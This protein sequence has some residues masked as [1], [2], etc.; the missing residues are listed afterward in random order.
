MKQEDF[1]SGEPVITGSPLNFT[2]QS[3]LSDE[4]QAA[5]AA[6]F[7]MYDYDLGI[8]QYYQQPQIY[9]G[10]E[11]YNGNFMNPPTSYNQAVGLGANPYVGGISPYGNPQPSYNMY[12]MGNPVLQPGYMYSQPMYQPPV[13]QAPTTMHIPGLNFSGEYLPT[14]GYEDKIEDMKVKYWKKYQEA[15]VK[16]ITDSQ[17]SVYGSNYMNGFNYYGAP[18]YNPYQYNSVNGELMQEINQIRDEARENRQALNFKLSRLAHNFAN[19]GTTDEDI[20]ERYIGKDINIPGSIIPDPTIYRDQIR[21]SNMVPYDNSYIYNQH[22]AQ[23]SKEFNETVNPDGN[24]VET[25]HGMGIIYSKWEL[26]DEMHRRKDAGSLYNNNDNAFKYFVRKKAQERYAREKGIALPSQNILGGL[27]D[28]DAQQA[29]K[30]F[31]ANSPI[32]SKVATLS[33]DGTLNLSISLPANTGSHKGETYTVNNENEQQYNERY[34]RF[35]NSI[36]GNS[37]LDTIKQRKIEEYSSG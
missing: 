12:R 4:N 16:Q 21:F 36:Q 9:P 37:Y 23:V 30:D 31:I 1:Y 2:N 29:R 22:H 25:F 20:R 3:S 11:G 14:A 5:Q 34:A 8:R 33:D 6:S 32:L 26:E 10:A 19:D 24:L 17:S 15:D 28:F 7:G 35:V 13:Q 18:F 27:A